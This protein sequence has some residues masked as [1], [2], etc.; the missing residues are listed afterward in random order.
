M[1]NH[2]KDRLK[3]FIQQFPARA[4]NEGAQDLGIDLK[5]YTKLYRQIHKKSYKQFMNA[6]PKGSVV[7]IT[8]EVKSGIETY[9]NHIINW[10]TKQVVTFIL[11]D[12]FTLSFDMHERLQTMYVHQGEGKTAAEVATIMSFPN[13]KYVHAYA[14]IHQFTKASPVVPDIHILM[15]TTIEDAAN[16]SLQ[17]FK[18][19]MDQRAQVKKW[20]EIEKGY[21]KWNDFKSRVVKPF[22][23]YV[24]EI[25][26]DYQPPKVGKIVLPKR[27][28]KMGMFHGLCDTHFLR[29]CYSHTGAVVYDRKIAKERIARHVRDSI[30]E[31]SQFYSVDKVLLTIGNDNIHV[32]S[33]DHTT[34]HGTSQVAQTIGNYTLDLGTYIDIT[35]DYI[36]MFA[37]LGVPVEVIN[38]PGN[39]DKRTSIMMG[40]FL[41]RFPFQKNI[42][43][44]H[45]YHS[46]IY[47]QYHS[48]GFIFSHGSGFSDKKLKNNAHKMVMSEAKRRGFS[49][50]E[51]YRWDLH[52]FHQHRESYENL[53]GFVC[54]FV[55][56][57]LSADDW[58]DDEWHTDQL[59]I[60]REPKTANYFY[61]KKEG[62]KN[63]MF[64][65]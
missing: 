3:K 5:E 56:P 63:I 42:T 38:V 8:G 12:S 37:A 52:T 53:N 22:E 9:E 41:S 30:K 49:L 45:E 60:G 2:A 6:L 1:E 51:I 64:V 21:L 19:K 16:R 44:R 58:F 32:D 43:V 10:N 50:D 48:T 14:K 54:H 34:T 18:R 59:Y 47:S 35:L 24:V 13:A 65:K 4:P 62:M 31:A 25:L 39:H 40:A 11:G 26:K 27:K 23:N 7:L 61:D 36:H 57:S 20:K 17:A 46:R 55:S 29:L 15:G 33:S 28:R